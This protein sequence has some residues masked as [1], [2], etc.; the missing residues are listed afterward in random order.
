[1]ADMKNG[2]TINSNQFGRL[3]TM[4]PELGGGGVDFYSG[5]EGAPEVIEAQVFYNAVLHGGELT[6]RPEEALVVTEILEAI[7]ESAKTGK[8]I[9]F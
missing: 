7:Y 8:T 4:K 9:E 6:V 1:G 5:S 3:T 2:L